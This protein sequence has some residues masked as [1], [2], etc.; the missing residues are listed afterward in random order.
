MGAAMGGSA[1]GLVVE[2]RAAFMG[3]CGVATGVISTTG[4]T[5]PARHR[6]ET[7]GRAGNVL[8]D[9]DP[10]SVTSC[11]G[12]RGTASALEVAL[13]TSG[14]A[15]T[16]RASGAAPSTFGGPTAIVAV[17]AAFASGS[18]IITEP[19]PIVVDPFTSR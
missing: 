5:S 19:G 2:G 3:R 13:M 4:S 14:L 7:A 9:L 1:T 12:C 11:G 17:V 15:F 8:A 10:A 18:C 6:A 16:G